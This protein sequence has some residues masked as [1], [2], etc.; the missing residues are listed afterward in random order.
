M[1][2]R[3]LAIAITVSVPL[4]CI[5]T[6]V[7]GHYYGQWRMDTARVEVLEVATMLGYEPSAHL[8][9]S[10]QQRNANLV[11]GSRD[12]VTTLL[13][14]TSLTASEFARR[15]EQLPWESVGYDGSINAW[16]ELYM[17]I[18][19]AVNKDHLQDYSDYNLEFIGKRHG[20]WDVRGKGM[21]IF[22][23]D[24]ATLDLPLEYN[25]KT[26]TKNVVGIYKY[27]SDFPIWIYCPVQRHTQ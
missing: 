2:R 22:Y 9:D 23:F 4:I 20:T 24:L 21:R 7:F 27:R 18:D 5:G 8:F 16:A 14:T 17:S 15:L 12:C 6:F 19:L 26:F 25:G 1:K 11:N 3:Y 13:Y 10:V